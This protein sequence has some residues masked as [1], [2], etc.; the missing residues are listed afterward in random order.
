[1]KT[2]QQ[3]ATAI[4]KLRKLTTHPGVNLGATFPVEIIEATGWANQ[5]M[6]RFTVVSEKGMKQIVVT[7][8]SG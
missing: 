5:D 2:A 1:M 7:K 8:L 4:A 3:H 6:L